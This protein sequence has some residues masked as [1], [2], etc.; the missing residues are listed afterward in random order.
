MSKI[1]LSKEEIV[2]LAHCV[3]QAIPCE[4]E[5][6]A[7]TLNSCNTLAKHLL[8]HCSSVKPQDGS[9]RCGYARCSGRNHN[10]SGALKV[11]VEL[12][13]L[14]RVA[15]PCPARECKEVFIRVQQLASHFEHAHREL[16]GTRVL[17]DAF[18]PLAVLAPPRHLRRLS[19]LPQRGT[20]TD[21]F[22]LPISI[23]PIHLGHSQASA[24]QSISR[25]W[26]RL[27]VQDDE[28]DDNPIPFDNLPSLQSHDILA[29]QVVY[30]EVR[31]KLPLSRQPLLSRPQSAVYPPVRPEEPEQNTLYQAFVSRVDELVANGALARHKEAG[32]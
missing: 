11:H 1:N 12:S 2:N 13:H 23:P 22:L 6:C 14:S 8:R 3:I 25:R 7:I 9:F 31:T 30:I 20:R 5:N 17:I 27:N 32:V 19:P 26:S 15:V 16:L 29:R 18:A 28:S 10:S 4:W 24:S 21:L